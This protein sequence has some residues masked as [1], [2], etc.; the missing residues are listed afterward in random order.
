M[1]A[2][3]VCQLCDG[4]C[5]IGCKKHTESGC[6]LLYQ[7]RPLSCQLYPFVRTGNDLILSEDCP[8]KD[9]FRGMLPEA[10]ETIDVRK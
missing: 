5:C 4:R 3:S 7:E 9:I 6:S 1:I 8:N 2:N 10:W